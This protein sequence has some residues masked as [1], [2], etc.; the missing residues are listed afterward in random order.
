MRRQMDEQAGAG[1]DLQ[2]AVETVAQAPPRQHALHRLLYDPL[3]DALQH[4]AAVISSQSANLAGWTQLGFHAHAYAAQLT[5]C[6][7]RN[8]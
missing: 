7:Q 3:R 1:G 2:V 6:P 8:T 4:V 5:S